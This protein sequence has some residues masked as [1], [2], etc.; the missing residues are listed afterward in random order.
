MEVVNI[1]MLFYFGLLNYGVIFVF[2]KN[3]TI[4]VMSNIF[5]GRE[6]CHYVAG[7]FFA[8]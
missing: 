7:I 6:T 3:V 8:C 5:S 2:C 4:F 1:A